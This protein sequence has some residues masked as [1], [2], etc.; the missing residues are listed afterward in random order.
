MSLPLVVTRL[1][2]LSLSHLLDRDHVHPHV[3]HSRTPSLPPILRLPTELLLDILQRSVNSRPGRDKEPLRILARHHWLALSTVCSK[4]HDV[5]LGTQMI[6]ADMDIWWLDPR[7]ET[8]AVELIQRS[9][10][11]AGTS[12]LRLTVDVAHTY[13]ARTGQPIRR[14]TFA[15]LCAASER[16]HSL[17]LRVEPGQLVDLAP[18]HGKLPLLERLKLSR[19]HDAADRQFFADCNLFE[20]APAL[21]SLTFEDFPPRVA[22]H[23][24]TEVRLNATPWPFGHIHEAVYNRLAF[25]EHC[26]ASC[27]VT[28]WGIERPSSYREDQQDLAD[29][30]TQPPLTSPI[31]SFSLATFSLYDGEV[32]FAGRIIRLLDLPNLTEFKLMSTRSAVNRWDAAAFATFTNRSPNITTL[33]IGDTFISPPALLQ[34]LRETPLLE[35]LVVED[36]YRCN[37]DHFVI[38]DDVLHGLLDPILVPNLHRLE[39]TSFLQFDHDLLLEALRLRAR[40]QRAAG[41]T[42]VF[43]AVVPNL[44]KTKDQAQYRKRWQANEGRHRLAETLKQ[45]YQDGLRFTI[46]VDEA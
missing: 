39:I 15:V 32:P 26:S 12:P 25:I 42:F 44:A 14:Q 35:D 36:I 20:S 10:L 23:Q 1:D 6:W 40:A 5:I 29:W 27:S 43:R 41:G 2:M 38:T 37:S 34:A 24:L 45:G 13:D 8:S 22:W 21:R 4:W 31:R 3:K 33:H 9:L 46:D 18:I 11:R 19:G 28:V 17:T 16:W 7:H 30:P